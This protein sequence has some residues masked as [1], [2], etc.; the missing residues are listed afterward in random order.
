[1]MGELSRIVGQANTTV[2]RDRAEP[3]RAT[4]RASFKN[5]P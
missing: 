1:M 3:D 4:I 2:E 5:L